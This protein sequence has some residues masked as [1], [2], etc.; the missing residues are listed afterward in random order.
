V[1]EGHTDLARFGWSKVGSDEEAASLSRG[2]I[3][4]LKSMIFGERK[5]YSVLFVGSLLSFFLTKVV[6]SIGKKKINYTAQLHDFLR[7]KKIHSVLF[8]ES[9]LSYF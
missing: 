4:S 8:V 3:V 1:W 5:R 9:L 6:A 2:G 7:E